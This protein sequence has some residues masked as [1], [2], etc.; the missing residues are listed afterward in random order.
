MDLA[1]RDQLWSLLRQSAD[2]TLLAGIFDATD[3]H[4][5]Q[6][7]L[8]RCVPA[9]G[10]VC[11]GIANGSVKRCRMSF[12]LSGDPPPSDEPTRETIPVLSCRVQ[13]TSSTCLKRTTALPLRVSP[14]EAA[15]GQ[16][17]SVSQKY[18]T[19]TPFFWSP[20]VQWRMSALQ[21]WLQVPVIEYA[22]DSFT[23]CGRD[24]G[25][26]RRNP[27]AECDSFNL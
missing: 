14:I 8:T 2:F 3:I 6:V 15:D 18:C 10:G 19:R 17:A 12:G 11:C 21:R 16:R 4:G 13:S 26:A 5:D 27:K 22:V 9:C 25:S 24:V 7:C 23:N 20:C 1:C